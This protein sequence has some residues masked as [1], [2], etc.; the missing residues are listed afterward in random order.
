MTIK[1]PNFIIAGGVA[2]GTSFLSHSIKHHPQIYLPK[3]MRP[4]CGFFYKSWELKKGK[5]YYLSNWFSDVKDEVAIG[6]RSSLYM[7]G[8]FN[9]VAERIHSMFPKMKLIFCLRNPTERAY[10]NYRFTVMSG[11]ENRSFR[12]AMELEE[13]RNAKVKGW[14]A[15]IRP[16]LC[17]SR[18]RYYT[19][20]KP[21]F[22]LFGKDQIMC[23]R[24]DVLSQETEKTLKEVFHFLNVDD[25]YKPE[26]QKN[27]TARNVRIPWLQVLYR[28][29]L[30]AEFDKI[31]EAFRV[32]KAESLIA[33]IVELNMTSEK[34][35]MLESD[36]TYL[37]EYYQRENE[38]LEQLLGWDLSDWK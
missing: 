24:S 35:P 19:E 10:A 16:H 32:N 23:I 2:T 18:G 38:Q 31:T 37:N 3:I 7:H 27:F 9:N 13:T 26:P 34:H 4:E 8:D 11:F 29:L 5:D 14:K 21:Y 22:D 25:S 36:R 12:K 6:E 30:G 1:E 20:L 15:E 33:K 17:K 28:H